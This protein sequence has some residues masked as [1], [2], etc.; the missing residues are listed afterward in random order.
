MK[1][2]F[3][4]WL[5][6]R[7]NDLDWVEFRNYKYN[8]ENKYIKIILTDT[9]DLTTY[10]IEHKEKYG[11]IIEKIDENNYWIL[12]EGKSIILDLSKINCLIDKGTITH[13]EFC[14]INGFK[15]INYIKNSNIFNLKISE[16]EFI[17]KFSYLVYENSGW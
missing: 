6:S 8:L 1:N 15:F 14:I 16:K 10:E 4:I 7:A 5:N 13:R 17:Q 2:D 3:N 12:C 11:K 9:N